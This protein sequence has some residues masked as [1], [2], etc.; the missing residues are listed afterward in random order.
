M[1]LCPKENAG[2]SGAPVLIAAATNPKRCLRKI[3]SAPRSM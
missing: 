2:T 3:T 1:R